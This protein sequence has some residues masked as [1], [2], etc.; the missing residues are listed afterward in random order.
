MTNENNCY[1]LVFFLTGLVKTADLKNFNISRV[2][3][4]NVTH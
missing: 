3:I 4:I 1:T 2:Q